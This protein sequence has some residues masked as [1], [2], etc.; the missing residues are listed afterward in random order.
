MGGPPGVGVFW[1]CWIGA[2]PCW[3]LC[4]SGHSP[5]C[6][7]RLRVLRHYSLLECNQIYQSWVLMGW[8]RR[9]SDKVTVADG[10]R[11]NPAESAGPWWPS[12]VTLVERIKGMLN[13]IPI[14]TGLTLLIV[15]LAQVQTWTTPQAYTMDRRVGAQALPSSSATRGS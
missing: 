8:F 12:T 11:T 6:R 14:P 2:C 13:C 15:V 9:P 1:D 10:C 4:I 7:F 5:C 3:A